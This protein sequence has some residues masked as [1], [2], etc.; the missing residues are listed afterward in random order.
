MKSQMVV[1]LVIK[2]NTNYSINNTDAFGNTNNNKTENSLD[3]PF[4]DDEIES[5]DDEV[6]SS[7][8]DE[9]DDSEDE[10][11]P[12][13]VFFI[14]NPIKNDKIDNIEDDIEDYDENDDDESSEDST[15]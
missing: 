12:I 3:D 10:E 11:R 2:N 4:K 8:D 9:D 7:S 15:I 1:F 14:E 6:K 13:N 5:T